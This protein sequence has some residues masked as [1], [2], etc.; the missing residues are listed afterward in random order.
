[1]LKRYCWK[2][3]YITR[4]MCR[5]LNVLKLKLKA[6]TKSLT[7]SL[8]LC[9]YLTTTATQHNFL[10]QNHLNYKSQNR[11]LQ[12]P[13][14]AFVFF[15]L[16]VFSLLQYLHFLMWITLK[17]QLLQHKQKHRENQHN[18]DCGENTYVM[19]ILYSRSKKREDTHML[20]TNN[21]K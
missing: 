12:K 2:W 5:E 1:M 3:R 11:L 15:F 14:H 10:L 17:P 6:D 9:V 20:C 8:P 16:F 4:Y 21:C 7:S 13:F 18:S 19:K